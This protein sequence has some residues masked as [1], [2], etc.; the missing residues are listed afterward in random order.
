MV[1][2]GAVAFPAGWNRA[3]SRTAPTSATF[4]AAVP[5]PPSH[6]RRMP[7]DPRFDLTGKVAVVTGATRGI[8]R[9]IAFALGRAGATVVVSSRKADAVGATRDALVSEGIDARGVAA[10]VGRLDEARALIEH[11]VSDLGGID[12]LVNNAAASPLYGPLTSMTES[13][14]DKIIAVNLKAPWELGCRVMP[15]MAARGGG[16]I[17]NLSSVDGIRPDQGLGI[18]S[19]SKAALINL[20]K[21]MALEWG[22][23]NVRANA[24]CPGLIKTEFSAAMWNDNAAVAAQL[25]RQ[26]LPRLGTPDDVAGLALFLASEA[27]SYCTGGV[28]LVDGG[29]LA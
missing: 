6:N 12:V 24:I 23:Q 9:A 29:W 25:A 11:T 1:G 15:V 17:I 10:N 2:E 16:S 18:Y 26:P 7:H 3:P 28:Y 27:G 19:A 20:T 22:G 13:A 21:A 5:N 14:F 4:I 8:G